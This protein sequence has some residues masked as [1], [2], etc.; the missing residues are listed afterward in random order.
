M[1]LPPLISLATLGASILPP[2]PDL[3]AL[4]RQRILSKQYSQ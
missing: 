2:E 1:K 4:F 3:P